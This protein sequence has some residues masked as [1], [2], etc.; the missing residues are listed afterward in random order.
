MVVLYRVQTSERFYVFQVHACGCFLLGGSIEAR[1]DLIENICH[2]SL[3]APRPERL[4]DY[5][6]VTQSGYQGAVRP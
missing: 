4:V 1:E 3:K 6:D 5:L 2:S